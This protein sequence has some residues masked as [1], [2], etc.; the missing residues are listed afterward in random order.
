M[1]HAPSIRITAHGQNNQEA[2]G[3]A[4]QNDGGVRRKPIK[5]LP[6]SQ[7]TKKPA[8]NTIFDQTYG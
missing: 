8:V 3:S 2:E 7:A 1:D 4:A 6:A 5:I